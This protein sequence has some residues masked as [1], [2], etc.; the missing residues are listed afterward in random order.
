VKIQNEAPKEIKLLK[1]LLNITDPE[2][3]FSALA[4][5]FSP[6]DEKVAKDPN[7]ITPNE[8]YKWIKIMLDACHLNKEE[9]EIREPRQLTLPIVMQRLFILKETIEEDYL[10]QSIAAEDSTPKEL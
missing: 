5:A 9:S 10:Q 7:A 4:T 3:R 6:G 8:L 1:H 2:E